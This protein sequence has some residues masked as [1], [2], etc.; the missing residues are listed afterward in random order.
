[1]G[2]IYIIT[3][4]INNKVYIGQTIST[5]EHRWGEHKTKAYYVAGDSRN[6]T[7]FYKAIRKYG[8]D[9]FQAKELEYVEDNSMLSDRECYWI[10]E[11]N[12]YQEGYNSTIGGE[13]RQWYNYQDFKNL[14]DKGYSVD[15]IAK[16]YECERNTVYYALSGFKGWSEEAKQRQKEKAI[17]AMQSSRKICVDC[18]DLKGNFLNTYESSRA[19]AH[20][21]DMN[22]SMVSTALSTGG[23]A[24]KY[25]FVKH[26]EPAPKPYRKTG[27]RPVNQY[28]LQGNFIATYEAGEEAALAIGKTRSAANSIRLVC[29]GDRKTAYGY[30]WKWREED[31]RNS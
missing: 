6:D 16:E 21:L 2:Y 13:G 10:A 7:V 23:R 17:K 9:H 18:Y 15:E 31:V 12:S 20:A 28:D 4:D 8:I 11:Y 19:A 26:G 24:L 25:L 14:W 3:N 27:A 5:V 1:M 30:K 22:E 29:K